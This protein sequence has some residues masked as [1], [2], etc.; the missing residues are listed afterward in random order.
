MA[1]SNKNNGG[2][3]QFVDNFD[4]SI[5]AAFGALVKATKAAG[6]LGD[7]IAF[8]RT[9]DESVDTRLA[10]ASQRTLSMANQLWTTI[11]RTPA[12][13]SASA[14]SSADDIAQ[15]TAAGTWTS[16]PQFSLV[17]DAVDTLLERIDMGLDAVSKTPA[18]HLRST[19]SAVG[20]Q[21]AAVVTSV[22]RSDVRVVHAQNM[23]R[24]QLQFKDQV[25][26]SPSTPFAWRIRAKPHARVPLDYGLPSAQVAGSTLGQHLQTLGI[27]RPGSGAATPV[28]R[29]S[30]SPEINASQLADA[31][32]H[33]VALPHPYE[34]E[35]THYEAPSRLFEEAPA[36]E[37]GAWDA[38]PF[39]FVDTEA[40][41]GAML[42]HL[43]GAP[44][45]AIDLEHHNFR[46]F[47]GFT[48][49]IQISTRTHDFVVDALALRDSLHRLNNVT[50]DPQV[51]KVFHGAE[52][53]IV[54]LQRD[55]GVYVVGLF[56]TYHA[57]HVL[58]ME[59]HSLAHLLHVFC[60][61]DADKKYQLA[62]WRIRP[63]PAEMMRYARA[64][65]HFLLYIFDRMRNDLMKRGTQLVG[66]DVATPGL[67]HF[68]MLAGGIDRVQSA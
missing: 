30:G 40:A 16:G 62:D 63:I 4:A 66:E 17:T 21:S 54:W 10:Q 39:A 64:D 48:C 3:R 5:A 52:S 22:A 20:M 58:N 26:N 28:Q 9:L 2:V 8:H 37:P 13:A 56:D 12:D 67:P 7:D 35:I 15:Q 53:D 1:D 61:Y 51:I 57:S 45:I 49:L 46:S 59:H 14:I 31:L 38:T 41:L 11:S 60:A 44:E 23:P 42:S 33:A 29:R 36:Q 19:Q 43:A 65:T 32:G 27:S 47:Q 6:R 18:H 68:G 25:D 55:F 24:P 34:Y 50:A